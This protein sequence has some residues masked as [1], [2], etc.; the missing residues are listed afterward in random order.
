MPVG[1]TLAKTTALV[2]CLFKL[3]NYCIDEREHVKLPTFQDTATISMVGGVPMERSRW[4]HLAPDQLLGGGHHT[5]DG[6][7][8]YF[9]RSQQVQSMGLQDMPQQTMLQVVIDKDLTRKMP[10]GWKNNE[11]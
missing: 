5:D 8:R 9:R 4:G 7:D 1:I 11:K 3:R 10:K 2:Y 6:T